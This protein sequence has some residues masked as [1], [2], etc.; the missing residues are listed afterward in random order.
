VRAT[1]RWTPGEN[2][3]IDAQAI[4]QNT[5]ADGF[6][7]VDLAE[8]FD[9]DSGL[10]KWEQLRFNPERWSDEWYQMALTAE[11][12][13][14][15]ANATVTAGWA[16]RE[17]RYDADAT[18][19]VKA[20]FQEVHDTYWNYP[21]APY[22]YYN[23]TGIEDEG[24][25][26]C[27]YDF[28]GDPHSRAV[29]EQEWD[30]FSFEAR[31]S[32]S[33]DNDSR[34]S[35][36]AGVFYNKTESGPQP[37]TNHVLGMSDNCSEYYA[38]AEGCVGQFKYASYIAEYYFGTF[39]KLSDNWWHG[40]YE[41]NQEQKAVFG[42]VTFDVTE[43]LAI[44]LGGRW[45]DIDNDRITRN[46]TLIN[47]PYTTEMNCDQDDQAKEAWQEDGI[48]TSGLD[49][50]WVDEFAKSSDN[51]FVPKFNATYRIDDDKMVF[52]TYSEGF[53]SGGVN[54]AK[55][56]SD[57][58]ADGQYHVYTPDNLHNYE[59]GTKTTWAEGRFQLNLTLFHMVWKDIQIEAVE[60]GVTFQLGIINFPEAEINGFEGDFSWIPAENWTLTG[61]LGYND[62]KLSEDAVLFPDAE[63]PKEAVK[64]TRLPIVPDWK[65]SLMAQ[66]NFN[67]QLWNA[68]PY[69]IGVYQ[70][71]GDSVN[72]LAGISSTFG[73]NTVRTHPSYSIFNLR[74]GLD[75]LNWSVAL[76][77]D[78]VFNK[79]AKV[80]YNDRW[81]KTRLSTS[82][83][84]TFGINY[85]YTWN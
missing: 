57:F 84:R 31:L 36:I 4:Y 54:A 26:T 24:F 42:E 15:W 75:S 23:P 37:F 13:L 64:G 19:Y 80:L 71:Q 3:V 43:N 81:I 35:W 1:L 69:L 39:S 67:D 6:G 2:W 62:A 38:A 82:R 59:L 44:T 40:V 66:Y 74:F 7:D 68:T 22:C 28:G 29:D 70:Y 85:R 56:G 46:G 45:Y 49:L 20:G 73:S 27:R 72:S 10:G 16:H 17:T 53:R 21:N 83:P 30:R 34:W 25:T 65:G 9:A 76:Y 58:G 51:G 60:S 77:V 33:S 32:S 63:E 55:R 50:C 52:F 12:S 79:Y 61:T 47:P 5:D 8:G 41:T 78:N 11:G 48:A 14:G 18:A